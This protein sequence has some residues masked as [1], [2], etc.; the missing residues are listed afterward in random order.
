[1]MAGNVERERCTRC[2]KCK[3]RSDGIYS[4]DGSAVGTGDGQISSGDP[5]KSVIRKTGDGVTLILEFSTVE[6][7]GDAAPKRP[8]YAG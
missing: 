7:L 1:M 8:D 3:G 2:A 5:G 4:V 6:R